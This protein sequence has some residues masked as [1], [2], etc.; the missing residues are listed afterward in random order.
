VRDFGTAESIQQLTEAYLPDDEHLG[1]EMTAV[2][3]RILQA[4]GAYRCP[5]DGGFVYLIYTDIAIAEAGEAD[6]SKKIQCA[7]HGTAYATYVCRHLASDPSQEWFSREPDEE[8]RWPDAWCKQCDTFFQE[9]GEWNEKNEK[10][11]EIKLICHHCYE[12][13][14]A[15]SSTCP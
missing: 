9:Q 6:R 8:N 11:L 3:A 2:A 10:K 7:T 1:W 5:G 4:K 14:R 15:E 12:K 13:L